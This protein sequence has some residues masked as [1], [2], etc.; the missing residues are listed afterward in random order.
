MKKVVLFF[1]IAKDSSGAGNPAPLGLSINRKLIVFRP[2]GTI[3]GNKRIFHAVKTGAVGL[4]VRRRV[5][6]IANLVFY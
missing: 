2:V 6:I 4:D 5:P 3:R 1:I